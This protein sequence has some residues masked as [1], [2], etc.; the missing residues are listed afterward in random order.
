MIDIDADEAEDIRQQIIKK[1]T[2]FF[3][4]WRPR[5]DAFV[6]GE[7]KDEQRIAQEEPV[8][9]EP[10]ITKRESEITILLE[11]L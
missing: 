3:H 10:F 6:Y 1:N 7:R 11:H 4:R 5:N 2:L 8:Q 9:I